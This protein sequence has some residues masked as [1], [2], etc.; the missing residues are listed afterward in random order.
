MLGSTGNFELQTR[1]AQDLGEFIRH[2]RDKPIAL[3]TFT[4]QQASNLAI[5]FCV[6]IAKGQILQFPFQLA[7]AQSMRQRCVHLKHLPPN[8]STPLLI[9]FHR[10]DR[11]RALRQFYQGNA[12]IVDQ[13]NQHFAYIV[14][15]VM[16]LAKHRA[17]V[18]QRQIADSCHTQHAL[19]QAN[20]RV[21]ELRSHL[22]SIETPL[23]HCAVKHTR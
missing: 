6:S 3:Q 23:P 18:L 20:H 8:L 7:D 15:L 17:L 9:L 1:V 10:A 22:L 5:G 19:Y 2:F 11:T 13:R 12:Y 14:F 16:R 21:T 4:I